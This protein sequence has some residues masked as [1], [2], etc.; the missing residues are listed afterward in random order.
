MGYGLYGLNPKIKTPK[1]EVDYTNKKD[2]PKQMEKLS[3]WEKENPGTY[4]RNNV[5]W[6]RGLW[7]YVC[8]VGKKIMTE[9]DI[10]AGHSNSGDTIS[11]TKATKLA[12]LIK[13]ELTNGKTKEF[14]K[15]Y[16]KKRKSLPQI[17]C[18][19][20]EGTGERKDKTCH[21]CKGTGKQKN[22]MSHYPVS[23]KN[24]EEFQKFMEQSGGFK[25]C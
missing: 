21:N 14:V 11:K 6:W 25:I 4:F 15:K 10:T 5:W 22:W 2:F 8:K 9:K 16:E 1:P 19:L 3:K 7:S 24:I 23:I 20:C 12:K 17:E 18:F 13:E